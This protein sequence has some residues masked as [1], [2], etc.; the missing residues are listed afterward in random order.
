MLPP[1]TL[2]ITETSCNSE[3]GPELYL[4]QRFEA[5]APNNAARLP[6]PDMAIPIIVSIG[7]IRWLQEAWSGFGGGTL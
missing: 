6:P 4:R 3:C 1:D 7:F 2:E 5:V